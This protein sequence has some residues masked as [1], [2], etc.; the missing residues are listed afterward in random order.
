MTVNPTMRPIVVVR[1]AEGFMIF[2]QVVTAN[3]A[4]P[5]RITILVVTESAP[6]I[7]IELR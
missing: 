5:K 4:S 6:F 7:D 1:N 3:S 2:F